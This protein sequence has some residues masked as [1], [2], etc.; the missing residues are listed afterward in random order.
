MLTTIGKNLV[1]VAV[2]FS[3][4]SLGLSLWAAADRTD[5]RTLTSKIQAEKT[6]LQKEKDENIRELTDLLSQAASQTRNIAR[7]PDE[8]AANKD[9]SVKAALEEAAKNEQELKTLDGDLQVN[10]QARIERFNE[11][12]KTRQDVQKE[13]D[14]SKQLS[15]VITP[16]ENLQRQGRRSFRDTIAALQVAKAEAERRIEAMQPDLYNAAIRLQSLQ[17][18]LDGLRKRADELKLP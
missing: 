17:L 6:V 15:L 5:F 11:L 4:T 8:I 14:V 1:Y 16:D 3:L 13:K 7:G 12:Q 10:I 9:I 18:R 2:V